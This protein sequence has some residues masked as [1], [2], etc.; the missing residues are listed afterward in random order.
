MSTPADWPMVRLAAVAEI[1][2]RRPR[3]LST[4]SPESEVTF[5]PMPSVEQS[6]GTISSP[7]TRRFSEVRTGFT[8]FEEG[9]V[10]F[11]KITP[12][13][14]NGKSAI[15]YNLTN[16]IGFGSTEFHVIRPHNMKLL[17]EWIWHFVRQHSYR[18]KATRHF[19][20]AVGQ[21][22]VPSSFLK[23]TCIPLPPLPEQRRIVTRIKECMERIEEIERLRGLQVSET[24]GLVESII[25]SLADQSWPRKPIHELVESTRNGWSGKQPLDGVPVGILRLSCVH[26]RL[27]RDTDTKPAVVDERIQEE[28]HIVKDDVFLVRGNG[29]PQLVGR[30]AIVNKTRA[31]VVFGDLLIRMRPSQTVLAEFL[32]L[33]FH[34]AGVRHQVLQ[35]AKTAAG[36]WKIN[37]QGLANITIPVPPLAAQRHFV[38]A[39][40]EALQRAR[41]LTSRLSSSEAAYLRDAVLRMAFAGEL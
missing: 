6:S 16:G 4:L 23:S 19:Q 32:N 37:Q 3:V 15:A 28:F 27:I 30:T 29:S 12:C 38:Q 9:D 31:D 36:I 39:A 35:H 10:L 21:Q 5:V 26:G 14:Q 41:D 33:I 2:P 20:G 24:Q 40:N 18:T 7:L 17:P 1:N 11:A 25:D 8:Y 22:R 34:T 13:M